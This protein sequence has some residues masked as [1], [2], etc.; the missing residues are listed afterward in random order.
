MTYL[1]YKL[2]FIHEK[3]FLLILSVESLLAYHKWTL[4]LSG[5]DYESQF[6]CFS[7]FV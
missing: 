2:Q 5:F 6:G 4:K 1:Q 7:F 3:H